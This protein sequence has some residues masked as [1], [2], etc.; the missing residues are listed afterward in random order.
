MTY[1]DDGLHPRIRAIDA[2]DERAQERFDRRASARNEPPRLFTLTRADQIKSKAT[3]WLLPDYLVRDTLAGVIGPPGV[4]KSFLVDD[5]ACR[6][7]TATAW[8]GREVKR[9]AVF[10]LGG[11]GLRGKKKR[12]DGW[13]K[14]HGVSL[15]GAPLFIASGLPFL[16]DPENAAQSVDIIR[17]TADALADAGGMA[18]S[19]IIVDTLARA[20]NGSDE[21]STSDMGKFV[22]ALD[23][24]RSEWGACVLAVHHSGISA[25][26]RA[27]GSS[28]FP[29]SL[30]SDFYLSAQGDDKVMLAAGTKAK[31]WRKP[32]SVLL[33][34]TEVEVEVP[35]D[36]GPQIETTLTLHDLGGAAIV[37]AAKR[38]RALELKREGRSVRAIE[39]EVGVPRSTVARWIK[40]D[41]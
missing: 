37:E 41:E 17:E 5:W 31:D 15:A 34:K 2:A 30:D 1:T 4:C 39:A 23:A 35:G 24:L 22:A 27:R 10:I 19:L 29:A 40:D 26:G 7:A 14:S 33:T 6:I 25:E 20:M 38:E 28:N 36:D 12:L 32:P 13:E 8:R 16:C 3:D 18:P 21:N 9:G 11:E